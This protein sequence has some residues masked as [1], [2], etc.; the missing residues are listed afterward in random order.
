MAICRSNEMNAVRENR[1]E[2]RGE[3][4]RER[5]ER[6]ERERERERERAI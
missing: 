3:R 1:G 2:R 5:R 6:G 4:E